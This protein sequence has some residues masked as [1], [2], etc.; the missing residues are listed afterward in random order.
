MKNESGEAELHEH[1]RGRAW[2]A[3]MALGLSDGMITSLSFLTGFAGIIAS[4][5]LIRVTGAAAMLAVIEPLYVTRQIRP[6]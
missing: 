6:R 1:I 3:D 4:L 2:I 5:Q